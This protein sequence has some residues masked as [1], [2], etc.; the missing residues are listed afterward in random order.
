MKYIALLSMVFVF[1][2]QNSTETPENNAEETTEPIESADN[3][4]LNE[5]LNNSSIDNLMAESGSNLENQKKRYEPFDGVNRKPNNSP[6][7]FNT[8]SWD[9]RFN[10]TFP[11]EPNFEKFTKDDHDSY[12][13]RTLVDGIIYEIAVEDYEKLGADKIDAGFT[14]YIHETFISN[15]S[16]EVRDVFTLQTAEDVYGFAS[17]Y[18]YEINNRK[19]LA[20]IVSFGF[21]DKMVRFTVSA[22]GQF[23]NAVRLKE[24][25]DAFE[26][27]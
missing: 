2:C 4:N 23:E 17:C 22:K 27:L 12:A 1:A 6:L 5:E 15:F 10:Y 16:G 18:S 25:I 21:Q 20:D 13:A 26:I 3:N 9:D 24:F 14:N 8:Y 11:V 19:Y 7:N